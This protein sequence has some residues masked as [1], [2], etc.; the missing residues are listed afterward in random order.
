MDF[1][2]RVEVAPNSTLTLAVK[3]GKR[4]RE[5]RLRFEVE[6]ALVAPKTHPA[7]TLKAMP[8]P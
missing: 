4:R 5:L 8:L 2:D 7:I 3:P 6:N 1:A